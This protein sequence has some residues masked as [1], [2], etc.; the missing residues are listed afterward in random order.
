MELD[1]FS[2]SA[3]LAVLALSV[4]HAVI[5]PDHYLPFILLGRARRWSLR[6]TLW[7][8]AACGIGHVVSSLALG[9][10][11]LFL[12]A[13]VDAIAGVET[14]RGRVAAWGLIAFG[15]AYALW[16]LRAGSRE[17]LHSHSG[18]V[19]LHRGGDHAHGHGELSDQ[20]GTTF[21]AL[22]IV[23]VLGPCEPLVPLFVLPASQG[24]WSLAGG[25][26]AVF[27]VST[28]AAM[29]ALVAFGLRW[30]LAARLGWMERWTHAVAGS[31]VAVCGAA[32]LIAH[33]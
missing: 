13:G 16:G 14:Q 6:R 7:I 20:R 23:F 28:I 24:R 18:H 9:A 30:S 10:L 1:A 5:G 15:L 3:I 12:G 19:H 26:A 33:V 29:L 27:A 4:L 2:L 22:F 17:Q 25:M 11:G 31:L 21:W 8:T 32:I